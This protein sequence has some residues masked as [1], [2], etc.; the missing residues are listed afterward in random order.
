MNNAD[1]LEQRAIEQA[2]VSFWAFRQFMNP[3]MKKGW[4]QRDVARHLQQ[5]WNDYLAG[6]RPKLVIEAPPQHGKSDSVVEF[7]AWIAGHAPHLKTIYGSFSKR[8]GVRA[9]KKL[10]RMFDSAKYKQVFPGHI[11]DESGTTVVKGKKIRS[12]ELLEYRDGGSFR[13]VTTG[14][15]VTGE[16]LDIGVI[17]DPI[18]GRKSAGSE[19]QRNTAW[20][21]T[22]D[23][24]LTRFADEAA[25]LAILTRWH[26]DDP[27]GRYLKIYPETKV[28]K[29]PAVSE[30][31]AQ[32]M[33]HDPRE[34]GSNEALFP[35]L[36]S[37]D[38][39][40]LQKKAMTN[41]SWQS[42]YQQNPIEIGGQIIKTV[43]FK[44]YD[45]LPEMAF[46]K[47][48]GDTAQKTKEANDYSVF[49][50]WGLSADGRGLYL[51]DLIRGKWEAPPLKD[52]AVN[53]WRKHKKLENMHGYLRAMGIEDKA[54]GT[55]LIQQ[56]QMEVSPPIP[57]EA[58][59]RDKDKLTRVMDVLP[60]IESGYIYV[61]AEGEFVSDFLK[62]CE[63]FSADDTHAHDDQIDPMCDAITDMIA[64]KTSFS[65][66]DVL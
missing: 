5:F 24:F 17:D 1:L 65:I 4:F 66:L 51:I 57:V 10:Q 15:S 60:Y 39:L 33:A 23:D 20:E 48:F 37:I 49:E 22:T 42:L 31:N 59:Q 44:R 46:T 19:L 14:G 32:L 38:F 34:P 63:A 16:S 8:L 25:F 11:L 52:H 3:K 55:G 58:I 6:L 9:N 41:V 56:I 43:K 54:S 36:K 61:P 2:R 18:K 21:W 50:C 35:E 64:V 26:P 13:N 28:L 27:I 45:I 40:M 12:S 30:P 29:Y 62:E 7:L 47:I 53:F